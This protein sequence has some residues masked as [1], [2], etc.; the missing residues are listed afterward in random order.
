[1]PEVDSDGAT[2]R[3][4]LVHVE[5]DKPVSGENLFNRNQREVG[6]V[7]VVD[8][9]VLVLLHEAHEMRELQ[10]RDSPRLQKDANAANEVIQVGDLGQ[11]VVADD[12]VG[13][14]PLGNHLAGGLASEELD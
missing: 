10:S 14:V 12:Q 5:E 2:V 3:W 9:I 13:R 1:M 8:G 11:N 7:L 6:K 4:D